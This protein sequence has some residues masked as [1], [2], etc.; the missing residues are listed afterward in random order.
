MAPHDDRDRTGEPKEGRGRKERQRNPNGGRRVYWRKA[1][2]RPKARNRD[3]QQPE[4]NTPK[5]QNLNACFGQECRRA[6]L[7]SP[8]EP[9]RH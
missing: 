7:L 4:E 2:P 8:S 1:K 5:Y 9:A 3:R 6:L